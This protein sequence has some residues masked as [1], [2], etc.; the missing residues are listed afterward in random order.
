MHTHWVIR[1]GDKRAQCAPSRAV[2]VV[3]LHPPD[4]S[5]QESGVWIRDLG[6]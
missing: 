1:S 6:L 2:A 4:P 3:S 5:P